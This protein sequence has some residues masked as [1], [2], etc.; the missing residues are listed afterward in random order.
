MKSW[1][2]WLDIVK[3]FRPAFSRERTFLWFIIALA[4]FCCRKDILGVTSIVRAMG[5]K[6]S[7]YVSLRLMFHSSAINI[8]L[9]TSIWARVVITIHPAILKMNGS[10]LIVADGIKK[11]KSGKKMPSVKLLHQDSESNTKAEY[12][13]GHSC[14][15]IGILARSCSSVF[16]IP[17]STRIHEGLIETNRDNRTLMDKLISM[18]DS[19]NLDIPYY[20]IADAYYGNRKIINGL[21]QS[22]QHLICRA[23]SN[24]VAYQL[25]REEEQP[26]RGRKKKYGPK[27]MLREL[28]K[29]N[30]NLVQEVCSPI[31]GEK[32]IMMKV[33]TIDL[34]VKYCDAPVRFVLVDH[35]KRGK[36]I[37]FSTDTSLSAV[38]IITAY[39]YRFKIEVAFKQ[40]V[41]TIGTFSYRF[42]MKNMKPTK[43]NQGNVF[44]HKERESYR[45]AM[46]QKLS[47][48][49]VYIQTGVIAQGLLQIVST[50]ET[51]SIWNNFGSWIRT[52]RHGVAPSEKVAAV[53]MTNSLSEFLASKNEGCTFRKF[54]IENIDLDRAEGMALAS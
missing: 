45:N 7:C 32:N 38:E 2:L 20:L 43:R 44:L 47:A 40:A 30:I 10:Y 29:K 41:W 50:L 34:A 27:V 26:K 11:Q 31:Y 8:E 13:M 51:A 28:W 12:I 4:G 18:V 33:I 39:G 25:P 54:L 15:A 46:K 42:W 9:L 53:S 24:A 14:Q 3:N 17:F 37:L 6:E 49:H 1:S 48:Y 23:R 52:K 19:L 35:P 16:C 36:V 21:I 22:G 5:L